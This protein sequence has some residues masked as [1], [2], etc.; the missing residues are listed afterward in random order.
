MNISE[1]KGMCLACIKLLPMP[2][3]VS[4]LY[5]NL[6][7]PYQDNGFLKSNRDTLKIRIKK[8]NG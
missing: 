1:I 5:S 3:I 8:V 7:N 6:D 2:I 4:N